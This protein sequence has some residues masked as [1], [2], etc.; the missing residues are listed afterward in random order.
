MELASAR[1]LYHKLGFQGL[2]AQQE[3]KVENV[4]RWVEIGF[5]GTTPGYW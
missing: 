1:K 4:E 5:E 2:S 3:Q